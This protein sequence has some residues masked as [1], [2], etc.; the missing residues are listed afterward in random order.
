[1]EAINLLPENEAAAVPNLY[2]SDLYEAYQFYGDMD[3]MLKRAAEAFVI[4]I[5]D[6]PARQLSSWIW[7]ILEVISSTC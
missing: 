5:E 3:E 4:G 6:T 1:M 7:K 2:V